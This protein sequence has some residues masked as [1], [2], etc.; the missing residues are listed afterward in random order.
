MNKSIMRNSKN[1]K[2]CYQKMVSEKQSGRS[3]KRNESK[4]SLYNLC[5]D[6]RSTKGHNAVN[7]IN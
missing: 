1:L 6:K 3:Q 7:M 5:E 2:K 4:K